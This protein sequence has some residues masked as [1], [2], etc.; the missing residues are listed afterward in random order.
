M[1]IGKILSIISLIV[2]PIL[3][4]VCIILSTSSVIMM[5]IMNRN[6][7]QSENTFNEYNLNQDDNYDWYTSL[8]VIRA[9][10]CDEPPLI[11]KIDIA[12][13]YEKGD[14]QTKTEIDLRSIEIKDFLRKYF[15]KKSKSE[16]TDKN[17][18]FFMLE[19]KNF[20]ND[21]ILSNSK[22]TEVKFLQKDIEN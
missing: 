11:I 9:R 16:I 1:K 20:I 22:I 2:I 4:A 15:S 10:T 3:I 6:V 13:G 7:V 17:E 14:E 18:D 19:I 21:N 8:G 5:K 12:L